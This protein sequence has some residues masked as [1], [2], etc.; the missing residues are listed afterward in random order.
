MAAVPPRAAPATQ[1]RLLVSDID[2]TLLNTDKELTPATLG[3]IA[4]LR[5]A[6][7]R[8]CL[9][10]SRS[11]RGMRA[12][13]EGIRNDAP[14]AGLN[15]GE[16]A[17]ADGTRLEALPLSAAAARLAFETLAVHGVEC[18]AFVGDQWLVR[19]IAGPYVPRERR[20]VGF[21]PTVVDSFEP[22][23]DRIGKIMG[24]G[25]D[26]A[27]LERMEI[28]LGGLLGRD[29]SVHRSSPWYLDVT[30]PTANKAHAAVRLAALLGIDPA[31]VA[32]IGDMDNDTLMLERAAL[33]IAMGNA[34]PAVAAAA[35]YVT[36]GNDQDGWAQ[37]VDELIL[38]RARRGP[39]P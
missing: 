20:A 36:G 28:E 32:C 13:L 29:A 2:G 4:A 31:E 9:V 23:I 10:S 21:E 8:L 18:W 33:G 12:V 39:P 34:P 24:S 16:I 1:I 37:A 11:L 5:G 27:L 19:D 3:A 15:G 14:A 38:P 17:A 25:N 22:H 7:V 6:G 35:H 30:H 26:Y